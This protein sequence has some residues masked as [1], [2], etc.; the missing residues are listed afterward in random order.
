MPMSQEDVPFIPS[1]DSA[2]IAL[3]NQLKERR[4][5]QTQIAALPSARVIVTATATG[6]VVE[7]PAVPDPNE[8]LP[9]LV[10]QTL[11]LPERETAEGLLIR[12][13]AIPWRK[14][15]KLIVQD[16]S[17]I[18]TIDPRKWEEIVAASYKESGLFDDVV[19]TPRSG[20][21]GRDVIATR[22]GFGSVR[23]IESVKRYTPGHVVTADDVRVLGFATLADPKVSKGI[24]STTWDFAPK[25]DDDPNIKSL[26]PYR[27]ELVNGTELIQRFKDWGK[28]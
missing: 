15:L 5:T 3:L 21:H 6:V 28:V 9:T 24:I 25:V 2:I 4:D 26:I 22:N 11:I 27:L 10:I 1:D 16:R 19:L 17:L 20:D 7:P 8:L 14:I 13:V 18:Y 12:A 23:Q